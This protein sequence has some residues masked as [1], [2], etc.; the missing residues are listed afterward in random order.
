[1]EEKK[2][3][4]DGKIILEPQPEDSMNDPL[5]WPSWRRDFAL[6]SLGFYCM[7]GGGMTPVLAAG[8]NNISQTYSVS[9]PR[10][11]LTTGLCKAHS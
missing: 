11:A 2:K 7:L 9:V 5:N 8:F 3:T 10:V 4:K 6:L 1:M